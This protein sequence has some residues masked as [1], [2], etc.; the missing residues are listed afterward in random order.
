MNHIDVKQWSEGFH[1][2]MFTARWCGTC[3]SIIRHLADIKEQASIDVT[4]VDVENEPELARR[5]SIKGV[6][7]LMVIE[8]G[9]EVAR[10]S[11]SLLKEEIVAWLDAH[12]KAK[13]E[14]EMDDER[15]PINR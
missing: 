13:D 4:L 5:F 12:P 3:R 7:V 1:Y 6:P 9:K 15:D 8:K 14:T 11:G 10:L 2:L